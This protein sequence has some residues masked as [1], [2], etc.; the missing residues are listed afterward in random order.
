MTRTY[1]RQ[2][3]IKWDAEA[4]R[5][6]ASLGKESVGFHKTK[7]GVEE[8]IAAHARQVTVPGAP[9]SYAVSVQSDPRA[10]Q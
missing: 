10:E 6:H 2:Y 1:C 9:R 4:N 3:V 5:Y 7:D 8:L